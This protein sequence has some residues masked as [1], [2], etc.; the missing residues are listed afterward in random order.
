[1][2]EKKLKK[3]G[4]KLL[5]KENRITFST[6]ISPT[7]KKKMKKLSANEASMGIYIDKLVAKDWKLRVKSK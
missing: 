5:G 6:T 4:P 1:M 7:T 2:T 3:R